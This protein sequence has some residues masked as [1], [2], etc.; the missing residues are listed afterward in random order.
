[1]G[2]NVAK[3]QTA[4]LTLLTAE[5]EAM[6]GCWRG[7]QCLVSLRTSVC[8]WPQNVKTKCIASYFKQIFPWYDSGV[9]LTC[10]IVIVDGHCGRVVVTQ[11][12]FGRGAGIQWG[13]ANLR[14]TNHPRVTEVD[15]EILIL[16]KDVVVNHSHCDL[17]SKDCRFRHH[18]QKQTLKFYFCS[19]QWKTLPTVQQMTSAI[20]ASVSMTCFLKICHEFLLLLLFFTF[21]GLSGLKQQRS[22]GKLIIWTCV[23]CTVLCAIIHLGETG[24]E[25]QGETWGREGEQNEP[26]KM[27]QKRADMKRADKHKGRTECREKEERERQRQRGWRGIWGDV[28]RGWEK[29]RKTASL[30]SALWSDTVW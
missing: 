11:H 8:F 18:F 1:M 7:K 25:K 28:N 4:S 24:T 17:C 5:N 9:L 29:T 6:K 21:E 16:L 30:N 19:S 27:K 26:S 13:G 14:I 22:L 2:L 10:M 12:G 23:C 15:I 20:W 3:G